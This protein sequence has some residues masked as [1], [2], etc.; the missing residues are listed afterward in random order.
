MQCSTEK[1][2]KAFAQNT[3][4]AIS[5]KTNPVP[6]SHILLIL[7]LGCAERLNPVS[8]IMVIILGRAP[9]R[10]VVLGA[11]ITITVVV[12]IIGA[13]LPTIPALL[14]FLAS[15]LLAKRCRPYWCGF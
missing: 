9:G 14:A 13:T 15:V 12:V 11:A 10:L 7:K 5:I 8:T 4:L 1:F 2:P 6:D 3:G